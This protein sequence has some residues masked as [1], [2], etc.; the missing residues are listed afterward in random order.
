M[1]V[2][3]NN[4]HSFAQPFVPR[5]GV[6]VYAVKASMGMGKT[7]QLK[8]FIQQ[9]P[10]ASFLVVSSRISLIHALQEI[11]SDFQHYSSRDWRAKRLIIQYESLHRVTKIYDYVILD[12]VRSVVCQMTAIKT[13]AGNIRTNALVLRTLI[14]EAKLTV[15]LD[16]DLEVDNAC[17]YFLS[18]VV[19]DESIQVVRYKKTR[20]KST[21][22]ITKDEVSFI[23]RVKQPLCAGKKVAIGCQGKKRAMM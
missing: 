13:N 2:E 6:R 16:A 11:L 15:C 1:F 3:N 19:P 17:P 20:L 18:N 22:I 23:H 8:N 10:G 5:V 21:L 14:R 4:K 7:T 12:K 9:K